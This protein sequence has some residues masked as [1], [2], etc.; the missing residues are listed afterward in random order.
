MDMMGQEGTGRRIA[1]TP[2]ENVNIPNGHSSSTG[3]PKKVSHYQV[4][5]LNCIKSR[6]LG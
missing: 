6:H 1:H 2:S 3:W 5:S 4:S